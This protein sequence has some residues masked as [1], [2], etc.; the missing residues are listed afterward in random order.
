MESNAWL[1]INITLLITI[2]GFFIRKNKLF[3][4]LQLVWMQLIMGLNT[5]SMDWESNENVFLNANT[6]SNARSGIFLRLY[7]IIA[8]FFKNIGLNYI[9]FNFIFC[10]IS[11]GIVGYIIYRLCKN[12]CIVIS[13]IYI[14][15]FI[16]NVIQKRAYYA[17]G[18]IILGFYLFFKIKSK[19]LKNIAY[20]CCII[21]ACQF[22]VLA[23]LGFSFVIYELL[24]NNYKK[25]FV[26]LVILLG[27]LFRSKF[28]YIISI[29]NVQSLNEKSDLYFNQLAKSS[30]LFHLIFWIFWQVA[31]LL[32]II[33]CIKRFNLTTKLPSYVLDLNVWALI[34]LP[35]YTFDPVFSRIFRV[36]MIFNYIV[37]SN[38]IKIKDLKINK[39]SIYILFSQIILSC[40][41]LYVFVFNSPF[42]FDNM[43]LN[44]FQNN[45]L[46]R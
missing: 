44:I 15:P 3:F 26:S 17:L 23:I 18:F 1:Y 43:V 10:L 24:S 28:A 9:T 45:V 21:L 2:V 11:T 39:D 46:L 34:L 4:L 25:I 38:N 6:T 14:Y 19:L 8:V 7:D 27:F 30:T 35:F 40:L 22:H 20:L 16:D 5:Y 13:Y 31:Y 32:I 33:Y 29:L 37:I 42:G 36:V 41:S 12:P